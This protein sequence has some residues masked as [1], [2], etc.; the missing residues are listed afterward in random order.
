MHSLTIDRLPVFYVQI[1]PLLFL[2]C[3]VSCHATCSIT[4]PST[5]SL[6]NAT[7]SSSNALRTSTG[8][9]KFQYAFVIKCSATSNYRLTLASIDAGQA[10]GTLTMGNPQGDQ[11]TVTAKL[12]SIGG[13]AINTE[14]NSFPDGY[15][16]G[17]ISAGQQQQV[18]VELTPVRVQSKNIRAS[19]G[20]YLG[21]GII[22]LV[23]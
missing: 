9:S 11:I 21:N 7:V 2:C 5:A 6:G 17:S 12:K 20:S 4:N 8:V 23:Y 10:P 18:I 1:W 22:N 16:S 3:S 14:F 13:N 19:G 15:Y